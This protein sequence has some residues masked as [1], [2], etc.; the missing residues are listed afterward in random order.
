MS[1]ETPSVAKATA[2]I[3]SGRCHW[4]KFYKGIFPVV[5]VD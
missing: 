2:H 5:S 1:K 3:A 4:K